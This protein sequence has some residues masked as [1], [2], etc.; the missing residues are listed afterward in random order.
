DLGHVVLVLTE[1]GGVLDQFLVLLLLALFQRDGLPL[2]VLD[3]LDLLL[4]FDIGIDRLAADRFQRLLDRRRRPGPARPQES[5]RIERRA[6]FRADNRLAQQI[7][8]AR[9]AAW[10]DALGA[11]FGFGHRQL[12]VGFWVRV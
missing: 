11:P 4:G 6:A 2:L 3:R 8:V 5:L 9:A 12:L 10:A 1:L 7:V